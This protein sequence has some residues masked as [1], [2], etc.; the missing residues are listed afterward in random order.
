MSEAFRG[1]LAAFSGS[2]AMRVAGGS[3]F[4]VLGRPE[5]AVTLE[6]I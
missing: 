2:R 3:D 4:A 1:S 5:G 6:R